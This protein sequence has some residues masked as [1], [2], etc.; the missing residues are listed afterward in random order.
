MSFKTKRKLSFDILGKNKIVSLLSVM[1]LVLGLGAGIF[2]LN[3]SLEMRVGAGGGSLK[4]LSSSNIPTQ[5]GSEFTVDVYLDT[6]GMQV[7]AADIKVRYDKNLL[8]G[9]SIT[10]TGFLPTNLVNGNVDNNNGM[11][12]IVI[13]SEPTNP[14]SGNAVIAKMVLRLKSNLPQSGTTI[15]LDRS[16]AVAAIGMEGNIIST[17]T[18]LLVAPPTPTQV[19]APTSSPRPT[20]LPTSTPVTPG[21]T[22]IPFNPVIEETVLDKFFL[23]LKGS[24]LASQNGESVTVKVRY[25]V[26]EMPNKKLLDLIRPKT[27]WKEHTG[28]YPVVSEA[29]K[30]V[31]RIPADNVPGITLRSGWVNVYINGKQAK[32]IWGGGG[33]ENPPMPQPKPP[34]RPWWKL[35]WWN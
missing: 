27:S 13:G 9:K 23:T 21:P 8:E 12:S 28:T 32:I 29:G 14:K 16:S 18:D 20:S 22:S 6:G 11:A 25:L 33:W 34:K 15:S 30:Q 2:A 5:S 10:N 1:L 3:R 7:T 31:I 35:R 17:Y 19:P 24:G 4:L 26:Q